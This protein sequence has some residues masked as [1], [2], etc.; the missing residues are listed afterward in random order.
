MTIGQLASH[1]D[2]P[3]ETIRYYERRGLIPEPRRRPS[4]YR[5]YADEDAQRLRFIRRAQKLGFTLA[6]IGFLLEVRGAGDVR[7]VRDHA[8]ERLENV[9]EQIRALTAQRD[10]LA[11]LVAS[12]PGEGPP[13]ACPILAQLEGHAEKPGTP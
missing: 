8:A 1:T 2:V 7:A 5:D 9:E 4:G 11:D 6:E 13:E 10:R 12:C 3:V